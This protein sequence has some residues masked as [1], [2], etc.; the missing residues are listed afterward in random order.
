MPTGQY[1][2]KP[3]DIQQRFWS[4]IAITANDNLCWE[5][6]RSKTPKGYGYFGVKGKLLRAHRVAWELTNGEIP[7]GLEVCHSCDNR[8]CCNPKHL[9]LGTHLD[10]MRDMANKGRSNVPQGEQ[11][12]KAKMTPEKVVY[13]RERYAQ[14]GITFDELA[15][16]MGIARST[17]A[18]IV[19]RKSWK[20][21]P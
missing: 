17:L 4:K 8:A 9:F 7:A 1:I 5:W 12:W 13:I 11:Q 18:Y 14:G 6:Q 10:N 20:S 3:R 16:E 15:S 21:I 2:R 19:R